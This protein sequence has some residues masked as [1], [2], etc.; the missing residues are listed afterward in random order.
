MSIYNDTP[1]YGNTNY[2]Y[3]KLWYVRPDP[4]TETG[5]DRYT[6]TCSKNW[7]DMELQDQVFTPIMEFLDNASSLCNYSNFMTC[8][9]GRIFTSDPTWKYEKQV[10]RTATL[11]KTQTEMNDEYIG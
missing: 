11:R 2:G 9:T 3:T 8:T 7:K 1:S 4:M 5:D 6:R 10:D